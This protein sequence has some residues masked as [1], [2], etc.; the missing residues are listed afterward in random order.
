M[1]EVLVVRATSITYIG[2]TYIMR[3]ADF[4]VSCFNDDDLV[5][6]QNYIGRTNYQQL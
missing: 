3:A 4:N 1:I 5:H 2:R 6:A